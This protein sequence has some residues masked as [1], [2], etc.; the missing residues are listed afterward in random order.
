MRHWNKTA[1]LGT[2]LWIFA[3]IAPAQVSIDGIQ[4]AD[5]NRTGELV[6]GAYNGGLCV[7]DYDCDGWF[8]LIVGDYAGRPK[9]L[10]RNVP[11][12]AH[13]GRRAL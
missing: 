13:P 6:L 5:R 10:F 3:A 1:A 9:K 2:A 7:I 12:P 8:D 4:F 11:D